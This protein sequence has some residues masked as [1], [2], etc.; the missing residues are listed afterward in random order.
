MPGMNWRSKLRTWTEAEI[1]LLVE[2]YNKVSRQTLMQLLPNKSKKGIYR[3]AYKMGL[4]TSP[5]VEFLNRSEATRREKSGNWNGGVR[6]TPAGY[7]QLLMPEHPRADSG[8]YVME[9]IAVWEKET[10]IPVPM[11]CCIHHLNGNKADNRIQ[12]LCL[13]QKTAHTVFHH[14]GVKRSEDTKQLIAQKAKVR[15]A[16]KRNHPCFKDVDI[17][18]MRT[19]R[20]NGF[21]VL[22]ICEHY[23]ITK[24]TYYEKMKEKYHGT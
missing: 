16:D 21:K 20:E 18:G 1:S 3:K 24:T 14:T 6:T 2:N 12:N 5:E 8:G 23:G 19:M 17:E 22:E 4:R 9:H 11:H 10:G 7:R 15:L 13:M